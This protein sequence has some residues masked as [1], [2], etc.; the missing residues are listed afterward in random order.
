MKKKLMRVFALGLTVAM[1]AGAPLSA[2]AAD[3][4]QNDVAV[5]SEVQPDLIA[6]NDENGIAVTALTNGVNPMDLN[7]LVQLND[8]NWYYLENGEL[9]EKAN[10]T[11]K[12][13]CGSWWYVKG[14]K[15]DFSY[16]GLGQNGN[17]R[18]YVENGQVQFG[19]SGIVQ[20]KR[21][22]GYNPA[23]YVENG[24]VDTSANGLYYGTVDGV[25]GWYNFVDG[26][27]S[28]TW[29]LVEYN[30]I[31]WYLDDDYR[32]DFSYTGAASNQSGTW[33]VRNG[34][35]DFTFTGMLEGWHESGEY[36]TPYQYY[37][38]NGKL[39]ENLTG[40]Y[41]TTVN[42]VAGWY[43]FYKGTLATAWDLGDRLDTPG[44]V[45]SNAG[46]W[47][48]IDPDTAMVDFSYT[49]LG[50]TDIPGE[51]FYNYW[52]V[53]NGQI[54]FNYSGLYVYTNRYDKTKVVYITGGQV[55]PSVNGVYQLTVNGKTDWYGLWRGMQAKNEVL[56][57]PYNGS[58]WG[59]GE[60][61]CI[62]FSYTGIV[63]RY[64]D[65]GYEAD[66][67]YVKNGQVDF[68]YTGWLKTYYSGSSDF[69]YYACIE[70]G[71]M[72]S[73]I[74][75]LMEATIDGKTA[76][77]NV[78]NGCVY[79]NNTQSSYRS[80]SLAYYNGSWWA[81]YNNQVDFSYTGYADYNGILWYVE[82]GR[83]NFDKTGFVNQNGSNDYVQNGQYNPAFNGLV[84]A[85]LNGTWGWYA[86]HYG[87]CVLNDWSQSDTPDGY[88]ANESGLWAYTNNMVR[89]DLNGEFRGDTNYYVIATG[90]N[91]IV[92]NIYQVVNG[93]V[94]A[95]QI[96]IL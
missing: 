13:A 73:D 38:V 70:N 82:N 35:V 32:V 51:D 15:I 61:G 41:Y 14:C 25:E 53:E 43:G 83:V 29:D 59:V 62:D 92:R 84:Y 39:N 40:V 87:S 52:Y 71:K 7:G 90:E 58:W 31:W 72:R 81:I 20:E 5:A 57:N 34:Q 17:D 96:E 27:L 56:M 18:W 2:M 88:M 86:V 6:Q 45:L 74:S 36:R 23:Y 94:T 16:N 93:L 46:G 89:F 91:I 50:V 4:A 64:D 28:A 49:G 10:G 24:R 78:S 26:T 60:D 48:Y 95:M 66:C 9:S 69:G 8:G 75:G 65:N 22:Y 19:Y 21:D 80:Y 76:W 37:F 68:S 55:D 77:W 79:F 63:Y 44:R 11:V 30:G 54:N 3:V 1:A 12:P 67:W 47:W 42:G 33:Y 85:E